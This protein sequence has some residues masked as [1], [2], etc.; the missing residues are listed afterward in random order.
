M[1]R[2]DIPADPHIVDALCRGV[3]PERRPNYVE[4]LAAIRHLAAHGY[5]DPQVGFMVGRSARQVL[6]VR[7]AH[8]VVGQPVGTNAHTKRRTS[9]PAQIG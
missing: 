5:T 1:A 2:H 4:R 8:G 3:R 7:H 6:R 9:I